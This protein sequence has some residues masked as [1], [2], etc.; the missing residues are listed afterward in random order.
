MNLIK[1]LINLPTF[2]R[3]LI[4]VFLDL[5]IL[6]LSSYL[7]LFDNNYDILKIKTLS[8]T[9][10]ISIIG[11]VI[12]IYN[13]QYKSLSK[14]VGSKD[15]YQLIIRNFFLCLI[16]GL[17]NYNFQI[18]NLDIKKLFIFWIST[19]G[20]MG[21]IRLISRDIL[22]NLSIVGDEKPQKSIIYG[23]GIAGVQL[24]ALL[25]FSKK[26]KIKYFVDDN[27]E[28]WNRKI[29]GIRILARRDL[30]K[31]LKRES[32]NQILLAIPSLKP[33]QKRN[34]LYSLEKFKIPI[35][36]IPSL[37]DIKRGNEK[38]SSLKLIKIEDFLGRD[39]VASDTSSLDK[40][41]NN[42]NICIF[43]AAG[44]IGSE[45]CKQL[46]KQNPKTLI[47]FDHSEIGL[48]TLIKFF[49]NI[50]SKREI[51]IIPILGSCL[52]S[53]L[54][55]RIFEN[56]DIEIV[57]HAAAYKHVPLVE[58][59]PI[60]GIKNNII[61]TLI[62]C[63]AALKSSVEKVLLISTD[64][65]VRPTNIMGASKRIAEIILQAFD[66]D[67]SLKNYSTIFSMVR[68]GNVLNS[69]GSVIPLFEQQIK[70][71]GPITVT[72]PKITRYFM[73]I[74]EATELV[75][76]A[77]SFAE[78]GEVFLLDMG[79]P[80]LINNLAKQIINL[81]GLTVKDKN[82]PDG[83]IEIVF[84]GLRPGEKLYEELLVDASAKVT[85]HPLIYKANE[86]FIKLPDLI[87]KLD[88]LT[89][90]IK[91]QDLK[92]IN[93]IVRYLVPEMK[94]SNKESNDES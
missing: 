64:K 36:Q 13:G 30:K 24:L 83:D 94:N 72:H 87:K 71:G 35:F 84:S 73:T 67:A 9:T 63:K 12:Y 82:N 78:G 43:G 56:Y 79:K 76:Q 41:Y 18:I 22:I 8:F 4:L 58:L 62:I 27:P 42:K 93:Q 5:V 88:K 52:D 66:D 40:E 55:E 17:V 20:S 74:K 2:Y 85:P 50:N 47:L 57:F 10:F 68:F 28:L 19:N 48:Y 7:I 44:S 25:R 65:A 69:S 32:I 38:I 59:N 91:K 3:R 45:I 33:S 61:S 37:D 11:L 51:Q 80:V 90:Y 6:N 49:E 75:L 89:E 21:L 31:V 54:V 60:Q 16:I 77:S 14:F 70:K 39:E 29:D 15:I 1:N 86:K 81:N 53:A 34:L 46:Y 23:A 26:H 92:K